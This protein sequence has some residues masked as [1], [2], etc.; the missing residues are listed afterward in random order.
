MSVKS[1]E[2]PFARLVAII[3]VIV[4][5]YNYWTCLFFLGIEGFPTG[6]WYLLEI[7]AETYL[8]LEFIMQICMPYKFKWLWQDMYLLRDSMLV[9]TMPW[10]KGTR[11]LIN[12]LPYSFIIS[13][14]IR[15]N[16]V[17]LNSF[18]I[19][20]FRLLKLLRFNEVKRF[21]ELFDL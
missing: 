12:A 5:V 1:T 13:M 11:Y 10:R 19:A 14:V 6:V 7:A 3:T 2:S 4:H 17:I 18:E 15:D 16:P 9:E 20:L 8:G 21:F